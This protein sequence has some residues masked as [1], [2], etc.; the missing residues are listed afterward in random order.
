MKKR[1]L[2]KKLIL[3]KV[4]VVELTPESAIL[5]NGM[6]IDGLDA[7][8]WPL[9]TWTSLITRPYCGPTVDN[10]RKSFFCTADSACTKCHA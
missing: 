7:N 1:S 8:S 9:P 2:S 6:G 3:K 5:I 10:P 4:S